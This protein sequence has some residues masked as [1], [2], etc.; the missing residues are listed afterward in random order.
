MPVEE[1]SDLYMTLVDL[2]IGQGELNF[3]TIGIK[4]GVFT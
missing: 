4:I 1:H 2:D 3:L